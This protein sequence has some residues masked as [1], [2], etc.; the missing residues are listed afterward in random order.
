MMSAAATPSRTDLASERAFNLYRRAVWERLSAGAFSAALAAWLVATLPPLRASIVIEHN[1]AS[2]GLTL[3][4]VSVA[5]APFVILAIARIFARG[6]NIINPLWYW[7]FI[8][9]AGAAANA[10][11]VLY[12]R[13]SIVSVFVLAG[14]G[15]GAVALAHRIAAAPPVWACTLLFV[16]TGLGGE[17]VVNAVLKGAWPFTA[18]DLG[19][20]AF[21]ALLIAF[22]AGAFG[23]IRERLARPGI[24]SG[25][26]F[27]AMHLIGL[28]K[29]APP[30]ARI[31]RTASRG[32][33][34][35]PTPTPSPTAP[36][37]PTA[38]KQE[39]AHS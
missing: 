32:A 30:Q 13:D 14:L 16:A 23:R 20:I 9:T 36:P 12:L 27:A 8:V 35:A 3:F 28:A 26:T 22:R 25:A 7:L 24:A 11:A 10:L 1:D 15:F 19:A 4:G 29:A 18:L 21:F 6:P 37:P 31:A 33:V 38:I 39:E 34:I 5:A 2:L 17:W